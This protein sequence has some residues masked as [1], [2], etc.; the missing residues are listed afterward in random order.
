MEEGRKPYME[1]I[2]AL[3]YI[4]LSFI[5]VYCV[6]L[7]LPVGVKYA[8]DLVVGAWAV[9]AFLINP[10]FPRGKFCAK[11]YVLFVVPFLLFWFWSLVIWVLDFQST[12]YIIRGSK[13]IFYMLINTLYFCGAFYLFGK[14]SVYYTF[15]G[16]CLANFAVLIDV[17]LNYGFGELLSQYITLLTSFANETGPAMRKLELHDTVYAWGLYVLFFLFHKEKK[18]WKSVVFILISVFFF[19]LSLK[20][21]GVAALA[22]AALAALLYRKFKE[23]NK[24]RLILIISLCLPCLAF[25]YIVSVRTGIFA[26]ISQEL[27]INLMG[28]GDIFKSYDDFYT[29]SPAFMGQGIRFIYNHGETVGGVG[30]IHNVFLELYIELGFAMWFVWLW[31]DMYFRNS[32]IGKHYTY[33]A[34]DFFLPACIYAFVTF[35]TDNT[36]FYFLVNVTYRFLA[37]VWCFEVAEKKG[38]ISCEEEEDNPLIE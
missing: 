22:V 36:Y 11:F 2:M 5:S 25:L 23:E 27:K 28:R 16:M 37:M 35:A 30:T 13:N 31:Y 7:R 6:C 15:Y 10:N 38:L 19:T 29:I 4:F 12:D 3:L 24:R 17:G 9:G 8:I 34:A 20:R 14:K 32:W 26:Q 21:I 33:E 18:P 1:T